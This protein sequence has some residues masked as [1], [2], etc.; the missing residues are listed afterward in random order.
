MMSSV[1]VIV[2]I[3][4]LKVDGREALLESSGALTYP[5]FSQ[6]LNNRNQYV[7]IKC[8]IV[9]LSQAEWAAFPVGHLFSLA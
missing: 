9:L 6:G 5:H 2:K 3:A 1:A 4:S 8:S 7:S